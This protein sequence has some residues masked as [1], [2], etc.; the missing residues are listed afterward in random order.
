MNPRHPDAI[1]ALAIAT[2]AILVIAGGLTTP[3]PGFGVV[4]PAA[5]PIVIGVLML[6]SAVWLARDALGAALP[7]LD[8]IDRGPFIA[9]AITTGAFL[10]AFVPI[11]FILSSATFL[12]V[13]SRILGSRALIRDVIV[14]VLF[15]AALYVLFVRLLTI[16]LPH[17]PLPLY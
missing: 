15:V 1:G 7:T 9:T 11:G 10:V 4:G 8:P 5:F 12:V 17:G 2:V 16:D 13:Q 6:I 3:D 14:A